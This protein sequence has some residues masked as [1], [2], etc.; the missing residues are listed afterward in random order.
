MTTLLDPPATRAPRHAMVASQLRPNAVSDERVV[1]AMA[2][3]PREAFLPGDT[4]ARAYTD[5]AVPL[6]RG[7]F[8]NPPIATARLLT[9]AELEAADRVLLIGAAGGYTAAVL[10]EIVAKVV[11]VESDRALLAIARDA[12]AAAEQVELVEA[13]LAEGWP[14]GAPYD[15]VV[16]DGAVDALPPSLVEQVRV[17]G[18][19]V[20]GLHD[21]GVFRL[22][23]G[24]RTAGGFGLT[25]FA[26]YECAP[27]PGFALPTGF[28]F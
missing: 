3:I 23:S 22:A 25:A 1:T 12:L 10:A 9:A 15:V 28:R 8:A 26:D 17:G 11:A 21:R 13:S 20:T 6:G 18:R 4:L 2:S 19:V 5:R 16:V 7:R 14:A 27:L 24:R